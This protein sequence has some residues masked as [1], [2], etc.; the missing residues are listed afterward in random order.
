MLYT[1][2]IQ[3]TAFPREIYRSHTSDLKQR[4]LENNA[5]KCAHTRKSIP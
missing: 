2:V 1:Y 4:M 3:S 5:G